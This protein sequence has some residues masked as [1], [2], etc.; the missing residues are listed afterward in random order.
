MGAGIEQSSPYMEGRWAAERMLPRIEQT[1]FKS[2]EG[3]ILHKTAL[4]SKFE[5]DFG[6]NREMD[7][8]DDPNGNYAYNLGMLDEFMSY[9]E[10][11]NG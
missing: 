9:K 10:K 5:E 7:Y 4:I 1:T 3:A 2:L 11:E 8:T 6:F